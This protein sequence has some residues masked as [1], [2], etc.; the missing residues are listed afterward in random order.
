MYIVHIADYI[1]FF[2]TGY[3]FPA[4]VS[5]M[6]TTEIWSMIRAIKKKRYLFN[7]LLIQFFSCSWCTQCI[8]HKQICTECKCKISFKNVD[9]FSK[10]TFYIIIDHIWNYIQFISAREYIYLTYI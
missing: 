4:T 8:F 3:G 2:L 9:P 5:E 10:K 1:F 7:N 6:E